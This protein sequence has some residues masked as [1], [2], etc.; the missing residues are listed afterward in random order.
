MTS[1]L[2]KP[3]ASPLPVSSIKY[4]VAATANPSRVQGIPTPASVSQDDGSVLAISLLVIS[5][6][7][8]A[9][10]SGAAW[11]RSP[12]FCGRLKREGPHPPP[13]PPPPP[14][15]DLNEADADANADDDGAA[16][17]NQGGGD[18]DPQQDPGAD[19][20]NGRD[21]GDLA[22]AA[23]PVPEDPHLPPAA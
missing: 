17:R 22:T 18:D 10:A 11:V 5:V 8:I 9:L 16:D 6:I 13:P 14:P 7:V 20:D 12:R 3:F 4:S 2:F 19:G 21:N 15:Q 23:A 1:I